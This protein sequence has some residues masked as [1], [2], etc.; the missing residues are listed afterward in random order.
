MTMVEINQRQSVLI[1]IR[2][3]SL[4]LALTVAT[5]TFTAIA[6]GDQKSTNRAA[7][8]PKPTRQAD[9]A[10]T[11]ASFG[12][13]T[14]TDAV[15]K[16]ALDAH[17]LDEA[18]KM[19]GKDG[20]FKGKVTKIFEPRGLAIINF[21]ANYRSALT[22]V[23]Q[24]TNYSKFPTLTKLIGKEVVVTGKFSEYQGRA[25]MAVSEPGQIKIVNADEK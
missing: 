20:A 25:Q 22:T 10:S 6:Q 3:K 5:L 4:A 13:I 14:R 12:T 11:N 9:V 23:V 19:V 1:M 17:A 24:A 21:D 18:A 8:F 16:S 2:F 15:Y 7:A